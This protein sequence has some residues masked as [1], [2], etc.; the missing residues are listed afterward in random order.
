MKKL[1]GKE[2]Q[3]LKIQFPENYLN[4]GLNKG[5]RMKIF[6]NLIVDEGTT[7]Q[8]PKVPRL[9]CSLSPHF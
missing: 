4:W 1:H 3:N 7:I 2:I 6:Q 9:Y 8:D 5:R